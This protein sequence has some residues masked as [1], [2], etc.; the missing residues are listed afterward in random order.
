MSEVIPSFDVRVPGIRKVEL[1]RPWQW[2]AAGWR[3]LTSAPMVSMSFGLALAI[4]GMLLSFGLWLIDLVYLV[5]PLAS[6]FMLVGPMVAVAF[7]EISRRRQAGEPVDLAGVALSFRRNLRQLAVMGFILLLILLTWVR[8]GAMIFMLYWGLEPPALH[9]L[10]VNTFLRA[11]SIPFFLM[12][13]A[14][15]AVFAAL[16]FSVTVVSVPMLLDDPELDVLTAVITSMRVV[17][18]NPAVMIFWAA[19]IVGFVGIGIATLYLG[20]IVTLP[21]IGHATWHAYRDLVVRRELEMAGTPN[22]G[23]VTAPAAP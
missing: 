14:V 6:G 23:A 8:I 18:Y 12:G 15:G 16:T 20:L 10:F 3:D 13:T 11:E 17:K 19:L 1:D 9:E 5:L 22:A 4:A 7:Y 2:L 21:L